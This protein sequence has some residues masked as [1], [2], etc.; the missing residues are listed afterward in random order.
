MA[1]LGSDSVLRDNPGRILQHKGPWPKAHRSGSASKR[2]SRV[3]PR[4]LQIA[5]WPFPLSIIELGWQQRQVERHVPVLHDST[6]TRLEVFVAFHAEDL[7][8][9]LGFPM[10]LVCQGEAN[11]P[12]SML[13][14]TCGKVNPCNKVARV[15][16]TGKSQRRMFAPSMHAK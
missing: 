12:N 5:H 3:Y 7:V 2:A 1:L 13:S 4:F 6:Q 10:L 15:Q 11:Q 8:P 16:R 9:E 14:G